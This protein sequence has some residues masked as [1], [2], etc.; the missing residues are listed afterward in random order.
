[1]KIVNLNIFYL[2]I[3]LEVEVYNGGLVQKLFVNVGET[4]EVK[5]TIDEYVKISGEGDTCS[6]EEN[7]SANVVSTVLMDLQSNV[8]NFE[9]ICSE[10]EFEL[11]LNDI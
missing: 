11:V 9:L 7:Y 10:M 5:L 2:K 6:D 8:M 3:T 1:M 4:I